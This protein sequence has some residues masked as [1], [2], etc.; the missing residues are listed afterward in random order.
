M[1][2][3]CIKLLLLKFLFKCI[4][5]LFID[6][7]VRS[8]FYLFG[9]RLFFLIFK[10]R[11]V[12]LLSLLICC[13]DST[14][15]K[16]YVNRVSVSYSVV[17]F[18]VFSSSLGLYVFGSSSVVSMSYVVNEVLSKLCVGGAVIFKSC[19]VDEV[20]SKSHSILVSVG[21]V[22]VVLHFSTSYEPV[23]YIW[24]RLGVFL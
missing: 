8:L 20:T 7:S 21:R 10:S 1:V 13:E 9:I 6:L 22:L 18:S 11:S 5:V 23:L 2:I 14:V 16:L 17:S 12:I 15:F 4:Q 19:A 24:M 3:D